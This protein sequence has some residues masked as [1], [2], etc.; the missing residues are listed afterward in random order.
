MKRINPL[1]LK[2]LETL[3]L[4]KYTD[5]SHVLFPSDTENE[6]A[7]KIKTYK[8]RR[9]YTRCPGLN[10]V[11]RRRSPVLVPEPENLASFGSRVFADAVKMSHAGPGGPR[12]K[13]EI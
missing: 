10:C 2:E 5:S 7:Q 6:T 13:R 12:K 9:T 3:L 11:P 4:G 1:I 8:D